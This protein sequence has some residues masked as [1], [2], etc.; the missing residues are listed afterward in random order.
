MFHH[1]QA[2]ATRRVLTAGAAAAALAAGST[3][4][5][6]AAFAATADVQTLEN[7]T[8]DAV[9]QSLIGANVQLTSAQVTHGRDVQIGAFSGLA[10]VPEITSGLAL[11]TGSLRDADPA[12][13]SDV[14]FSHSA[15]VG[16]NTKLTTTGDLGGDGSA[17]L[18]ELTASTTYDAAQVA[19]TVVPAGDTLS[20]A[21][22]FGSE[23]YGDWSAQD[24]TDALGIFVDGQLCSVVGGEAA[25]ISTISET[26]SAELYLA[27]ADADGPATT[28]DTEMNGFTTA[29]T[30]T[31]P[32][33]AGAPT[34]IVAAVADT[35]DG[36]LDTT[37]LLA[38][39]GITSTAPATSTPGQTPAP[40]TTP[41][42]AP[43]TT[44]GE[45]PSETP[46]VTPAGSTSGSTPVAGA[47]PRTGG[48]AAALAGAV[49]AGL[50]LAA[51]GAG[52]VVRA[53]RRAA[54]AVESE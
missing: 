36:Q 45:T 50:A 31:V 22:Q 35:V 6:S 12:A 48:D 20:I 33:T 30:C 41:G 10:L 49:I 25:G 23:E 18:T 38:A 13:A 9:A 39:G 8:I 43:S 37:L 5:A 32:V 40:T 44:P 14:D 21:Y 46:G 53:R 3:F 26:A 2:R 54:T 51:G 28:Y 1:H 34:T 52:L 24:Y 11:T 19:L 47:L 7:T 42:T 29:L 27:N 17:E 16:P 4:A 15:L